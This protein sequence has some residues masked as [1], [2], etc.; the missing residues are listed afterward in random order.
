MK[1]LEEQKKRENVK[2]ERERERT[3]SYRYAENSKTKRENVKR[4]RGREQGLI[5]MQK[6]LRQKEMMII[7]K[8]SSKLKR[9]MQN[10]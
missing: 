9:N 3:G 6:T 4:E 10:V 1:N 8:K 2:R 5:A 7:F